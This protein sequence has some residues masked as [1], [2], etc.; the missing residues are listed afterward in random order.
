MLN[1]LL[2]IMYMKFYIELNNINAKYNVFVLANIN[3]LTTMWAQ[4]V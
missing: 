2:Y 3:V 1:I 4:E